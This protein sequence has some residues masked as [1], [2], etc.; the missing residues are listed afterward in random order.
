M[1][2]SSTTQCPNCNTIFHIKHTDLAVANGKVRC[3]ICQQ[4]FHATVL[5]QDNANNRQQLL[6]EP[7]Q[8][9]NIETKAQQA[10]SSPPKTPPQYS[11]DIAN[12]E[13]RIPVLEQKLRPTNDDIHALNIETESV[14]SMLSIKTN[15]FGDR[16]LL[17]LGLSIALI[18]LLAG[19]WLWF[20]KST[21]SQQPQLRPSYTYICKI[22]NCIIPAYQSI[23]ELKTNA[24][25]IY[26]I[27]E[28]PRL[29]QVDLILINQAKFDQ[30]LPTIIIQFLDLNAKLLTQENITPNQYMLKN[31]SM[32]HL[33]A[34]IAAH[35]SFSIKD[36]GSEAV[37]Y[38]VK[39]TASNNIHGYN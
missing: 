19:Q 30:L 28:Q 24:I 16:F 27:P 4:I 2:Q 8:N 32:Q 11:P 23:A 29:L 38:I 34:N 3:G 17:W 35:V 20:N 5:Q 7:N 36:P 15:V 10:L 21:L 13:S 37:S 31:S 33:A 12:D 14:E 1:E 18:L 39:L 25:S 26:I 6:T 9:I 22:F